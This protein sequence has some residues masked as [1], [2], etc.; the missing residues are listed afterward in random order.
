M[1]AV[2]AERRAAGVEGI[3]ARA[4]AGGA[5][6]V[7]AG[8]ALDGAELGV[9]LLQARGV[10]DL[11]DNCDPQTVDLGTWCLQTSTYPLDNADIG[12]NDYFFATRKCVEA[13][14]F[15]P[16]A[17]QL[18]GAADRVK[19]SST[20]DDARLTATIDVDPSDGLKDRREMSATLITTQ[21][22][23]SAAGSQGVTEGS[24]GDPRAD[25]PDPVP[26]PANPSPESL[27]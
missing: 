21:A 13:G 5:A 19:L 24:R 7:E 20:I 10:R 8:E 15:V 1:A 17:A 6:V 9:E 27:Q 3:A 2:A 25:E 23:S 18:I 4:C 12:R 11:T 14:G 16:T 26:L 22:G